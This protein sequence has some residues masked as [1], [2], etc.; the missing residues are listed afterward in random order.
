VQGSVLGPLLFLQYIN[1]V[2]HVLTSDGCFCKLYAYDMKL[3]TT[4]SSTESC[5]RLQDKLNDLIQW[6]ETWQLKISQ[7][8]C[9]AMYIHEA[10]ANLIPEL[11]LSGNAITGLTNTKTS[12]SLLIVNLNSHHTLIILFLK[13][14][15]EFA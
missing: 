11:Q 14:V 3:Y 5:T 9:A 4:L 15:Q 7:S 1:D 12:E 2:T 10:S 13:P 6:S 8:K